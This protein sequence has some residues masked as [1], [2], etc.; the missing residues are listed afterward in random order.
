MSLTYCEVM[1]EAC[2]LMC[3]CFA[4]ISVVS[5]FR[6]AN[7]RLWSDMA[8]FVSNFRKYRHLCMV[9]GTLANLVSFMNL[10]SLLKPIYLVSLP[11]VTAV[12]YLVY[13]FSSISSLNRQ[14]IPRNF[15]CK[16]SHNR[17]S[18]RN[19]STI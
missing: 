12:L 10:P 5:S 14:L 13:P 1:F 11:S 7:L 3:C 9:C 6:P 16:K 15:F 19:L 2:S 18:V 8:P 4:V 17:S